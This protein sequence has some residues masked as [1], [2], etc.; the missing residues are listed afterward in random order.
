MGSNQK[1]VEKIKSETK[2][3]DGSQLKMAFAV[4]A[5]GLCADV[6]SHKSISKDKV[7]KSLEFAIDF[8]K[9]AKDKQTQ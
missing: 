2:N 7:L 3:L 8:A 6:S 5:G 1:R 4:L 9:E